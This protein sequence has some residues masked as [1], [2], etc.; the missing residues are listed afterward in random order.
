M[1]KECE[2]LVAA[3]GRLQTCD[4]SVEDVVKAEFDAELLR[5]AEANKILDCDR[6]RAFVQKKW[7]G[8]IAAETRRRRITSSA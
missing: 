5:F 3:Y 2:A 7:H 4:P 6:L 8:M 1:N